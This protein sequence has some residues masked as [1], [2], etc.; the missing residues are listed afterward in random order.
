M[1]G[2]PG[3]AA[4]GPAEVQARGQLEG[5]VEGPVQLRSAAVIDNRPAGAYRRLLLRAP[6]L[7][8]RARP[9]QFVALAVGEEPSAMLLRR[10]FSIHRAEAGTVELVVAGHGPGSR[11]VTQRRSGDTVDL[12]GPLGRPFPQPAGTPDCVLV[13]G[14]YGSAPLTWLAE[15]LHADGHRVHLVLGAATADRLFGLDTAEAVADTVLVTTED[16]SAGVPGRV[17]DVLADLLQVASPAT[18]YA[19][20]PMGMLRAVHALGQ[21]HGAT[22]WCTV[23]EAM[24]C[25]IGVCMTCVLPV[26]GDDG[27]TRMT[28]SCVGGPT[29]AGDAVRWDSVLAGAGGQGSLV[30]PDCLGAPGTRV[31]A[32]ST[33]GLR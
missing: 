8:D 22:T 19:C 12:V 6:E 4:A 32:P 29:F 21:E 10:A 23:E 14:G 13:G 18:V 30:P 15:R 27:V 11:W 3:L 1:S 31:A 25:G 2:E 7:A 20:G 26:R 24:A 5:Q 28:R 9:G 33:G 16:G 17:T